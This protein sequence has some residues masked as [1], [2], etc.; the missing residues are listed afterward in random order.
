MSTQIDF[1]EINWERL[2][3]NSF[4][5][6]LFKYDKNGKPKIINA[7]TR[8]NKPLLQVCIDNEN[9][10]NWHLQ[11][12]MI[13]LFTTS[14]CDPNVLDFK[15]EYSLPTYC[16]MNRKKK[17]F[18]M[19]IDKGNIDPNF[20]NKIDGTTTYG[21]LF[22]HSVLDF[23]IREGYNPIEHMRMLLNHYDDKV[24]FHQPQI[25]LNQDNK[26][27]TPISSYIR[28][29]HMHIN[30]KEGNPMESEH[31]QKFFGRKPFKLVEPIEYFELMSLT[32]GR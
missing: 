4:E 23:Y 20:V 30:I 22:Y 10:D 3:E 13:L 12:L 26:L 18:K 15:Q 19:M 2:I 17:A 5:Q 9:K 1:K 14:G 31:F 24:D 27:M 6:R 11:E 32:F 25:D 7:T 29:C 16:H 21:T 28:R 8:G